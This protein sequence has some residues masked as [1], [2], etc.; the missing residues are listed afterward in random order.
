MSTGTGT[1]TGPPSTYHDVPVGYMRQQLLQ[2]LHL[3]W[4]QAHLQPPDG[5]GCV[6]LKEG[7]GDLKVGIMN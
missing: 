6:D 3:V 4:I 1:G 7:V 5:D 2:K